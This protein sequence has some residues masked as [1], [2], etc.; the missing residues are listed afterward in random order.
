MAKSKTTQ[1]L[2]KEVIVEQI[3]EQIVEEQTNGLETRAYKNMVYSPWN[4]PVQINEEVAPAT[5]PILNGE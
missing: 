2:P 1:V 5:E 4:P 3:V